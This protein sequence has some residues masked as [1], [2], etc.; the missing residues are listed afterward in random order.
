MKGVNALLVHIFWGHFYFGFYIFILPLLV[1]KP[2]NVW[3]LSPYRHLTNRKSWRDWYYIK[4][5]IKKS[6]LTLKN[7]T[8]AFKLKKLKTRTSN[9]KLNPT[10]TSN[11]EINPA[12]TLNPESKSKP[13]IKEHE[14]QT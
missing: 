4:I 13:R 10:M 7:A 14:H 3:H 1:P 2:I 5:I 11:P 12:M 6:I 9:P 8:L